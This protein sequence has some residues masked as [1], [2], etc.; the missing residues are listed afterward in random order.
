MDTI[1]LLCRSAGDAILFFK[2]AGVEKRY[3]ADLE[4][5]IEYDK[6]KMSKYEI[7]KTILKR[8]NER[9]EVTLRERQEVLNRV[10][11]FEAFSSCLPDDQLI[12]QELV[13]NVQDVVDGKDLFARMEQDS[14]NEIQRRR[15]EHR[16]KIK[17]V[18]EKKRQLEEI[19]Q[20]LYSLF[21]MT[22]EQKQGIILEEILNRLF[23]IHDIPIRESFKV[24]KE[25]EQGVGDRIDGEIELEGRIYFTEMKWAKA[26]TDVGD[27]LKHLVR[28]S[29]RSGTHSLFI[30]ASGYTKPAISVCQ[31]ALE[32]T[33][34]ILCSLEEIV[35][36]LENEKDLS[37]F[38][39]K[40]LN[41]ARSSQN[42]FL[43]IFQ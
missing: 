23:K 21:S 9:G 35:K 26:P 39:K 11:E 12:A 19:K 25:K 41:A 15:E 42:P 13:S 34:I 24:K 16:L 7:V 29:Q 18:A 32:K 3:F 36:L 38:F 5:E 20:K 40:K 22:D 2:G 6:E 37:G 8:L 10:A 17:E 33:V 31:E 4:E 1:P 30:S 27:V 28:V 14:E 43:L